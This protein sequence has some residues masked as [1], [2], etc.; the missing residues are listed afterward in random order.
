MMILIFALSAQ[1]HL[2]SGLG[3]WDTILRKGAHMI[4]YG[5][6]WRLWWGALDRRRPLLAVG[7]SLAYA[8]T[9]EFHQRYVAG[10]HGSPWDW[11]IDAVG[12]AIAILIVARK[13]GW[14]ALA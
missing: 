3:P 7:L 11:A 1:P 13:R 5:L 10:R 12:V 8:A 6:L 2:N 14:R 9:D 4:E